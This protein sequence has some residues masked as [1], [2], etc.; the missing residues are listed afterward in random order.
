MRVLMFGGTG[1]MGPFVVRELDRLGHEITVCHRGEHEPGLPP[2]VRHVHGDLASF[3]D[4]VDGLRGLRPHVVLDM[5]AFTRAD[6]ARIGAFAGVAHR[7][8][9]ASSCDVYRAYGRLWRTEPG[10]PD[11]VPL[12]EDSPL[13]ERV[14][15]EGYDKVGV[16]EALRRLDLP[17]TV[18]RLPAVHGPGD[19]QHRLWS[20]LKRM[21]DGRAAILLDEQLAGWRW[22]RGYA[23]D[24]AHAIVLAVTDPGSAGRTYNVGADPVPT[25]AEWV[26]AIAEAAGWE[27]EVVTA[28]SKTLPEYL[29]EDAFDLRQQYVLDSSRI[30]RQL[31]Y[32]EVVDP[33]VALRRTVE[34]ERA[35]PP[36]PEHPHPTRV[37]RFDYAAENAALEAAGA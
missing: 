22:T 12:T 17:T 4:R 25:E 33:I 7:A 14:I 28:P 36:G 34:W 29:R 15:D 23:E 10:P 16:E 26:A 20:H 8:V 11:P 21:D 27:G 1:L 2:T 9:V 30:R 3:G 13:R 5:L 18:L 19:Y 32:E 37:D 35:N 31:G 24:V 6:A